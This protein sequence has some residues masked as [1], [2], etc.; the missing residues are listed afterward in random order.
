MNFLRSFMDNDSA[1]GRLMTRCGI[2]IAANLLFILSALPVVTT[3]AGYAALYFTMMTCLREKSC[4]PFLA[5]WQGFKSNLRQGTLS[6]LALAVLGAVI[7]LEIGWC[8][9]FEGVMRLFRYPLLAVGV[10]AVIL[11]CY[12][13]PVMAAFKVNFRQLV[14]DS[15][16]FAVKR[17]L[18]TIIVLAANVGPMALTFLD[19]ANLPTYAFLWVLCGFSAIT[20]LNSSLLL[21]SFAPYLEKQD[22][23]DSDDGTPPAGHTPTEQEILADMER[24]GM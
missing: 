3:G 5:F 15:V 24:L 7:R 12:L 14:V 6:L 18:I 21:K 1:F 9:Q 20:M 13:F 17:P 4:N 2:L 11:A 10:A 23:T 22:D 19:R 16:Y 8:D